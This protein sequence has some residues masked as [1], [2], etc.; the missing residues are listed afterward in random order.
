MD[1]LFSKEESKILAFCENDSL[2]ID[3]FEFDLFEN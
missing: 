1:S 2:I 3:E